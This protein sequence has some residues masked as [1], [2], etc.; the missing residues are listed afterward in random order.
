MS[1]PVSGA[2][3]PRSTSTATSTLAAG[4]SGGFVFDYYSASDFKY[5]TLDQAT[6]RSS[7]GHFIKKQWVDRRALR[8]DA[9][10]GRR[11]QAGASRSTARPSPSRSTACSS[12]RSRT[13]APSPTVASAR[14]AGPAPTSFDNL[15]VVIGTHV[16]TSPDSMPPTRHRTGER[17]A[18]HRRRAS[19]RRSSATRRSARPPRP[20]TSGV[21][22]LTRSGVPAGNIFPIG[23]TTITL[24]RDRRLR[25]PDRRRPRP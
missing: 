4:G 3:T 24:D 13:T 5:V 8:R 22:S 20:T 17:H 10:R 18:L 1:L 21:Q 19:R 6:G 12:A 11:L 16:D 23:V 9:R 25:Q 15:H 14:S 2:A 7:I